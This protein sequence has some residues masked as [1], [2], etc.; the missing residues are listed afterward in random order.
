L[1]SLLHEQLEQASQVQRVELGACLDSF[2]QAE[3]TGIH[4][5]R[6]AKKRR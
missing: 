2:G 1:N 5:L 4:L 6:A 3:L